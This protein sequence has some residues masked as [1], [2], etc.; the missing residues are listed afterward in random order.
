MNKKN[1]KNKKKKGLWAVIR[2]SMTKT[3]GCCGPG[4]TCGGPAK[5][6]DEEKGADKGSDESGKDAKK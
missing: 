3:G 6:N 4:E 5:E 2:E 1:K